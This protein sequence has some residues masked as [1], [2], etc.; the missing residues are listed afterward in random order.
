MKTVYALMF[1]FLV[2]TFALSLRLNLNLQ[3][4]PAKVAKAKAKESGEIPKKPV[5]KVKKKAP[6][7]KEKP[8]TDLD[9]VNL[10]INNL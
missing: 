2:L 5:H 6:P 7:K 1:F 8:E 10:E 4:Q 9:F 3:R